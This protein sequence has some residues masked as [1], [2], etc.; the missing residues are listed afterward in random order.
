MIDRFC[1]G[2]LEDGARIIR[3]VAADLRE[4]GIPLWNGAV[5]SAESLCGQNG[6]KMIT[7]YIGDAPVAAMILSDY[8]PD[9]W[10]NIPIGESTFVH[11]LAVLPSFQGKGLAHEM[12]DRAA[13]MSLALGIHVTRLDC[14]ADRPKLCA[15]YE[16]AGYRKVAERVVGQFPIAF[17][18]RVIKQVGGAARP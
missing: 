4:R 10:P 5:L 11:K 13:L 15:V 12:L 7:G 14:A 9:F 18:E 17:Y 1:E 3:A 16:R 2:S 8:D 6:S